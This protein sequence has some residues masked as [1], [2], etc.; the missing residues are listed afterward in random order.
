MDVDGRCSQGNVQT[1]S[2]AINDSSLSRLFERFLPLY[3]L[4]RA[5]ID[6]D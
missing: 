2:S 4:S 5:L 1:K 3:N 6:F